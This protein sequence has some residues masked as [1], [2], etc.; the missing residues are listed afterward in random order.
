MRHLLLVCGLASS[1]CLTP[2]PTI[3]LT[4]GAKGKARLAPSSAPALDFALKRWPDGPEYR[5]SQDRGS[6]VLLDVWATWC[7]PCRESLPVYEDFAKEYGPRGLKVYTINVDAD[8]KEVGPFVK[9]LKLTL[10]VLVDPEA[11]LTEVELKVKTMPTSVLVDRRGVV[12]VSHEGIPDDFIKTYVA[13]IEQ[14]L[15]EKVP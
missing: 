7:E 15:A 6:V 3:P 10:P 12:R 14:L 4:D 8:A 9:E 2:S 13:E 1:A 11:R 5:L